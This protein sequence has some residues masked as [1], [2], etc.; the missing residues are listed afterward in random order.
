MTCSSDAFATMHTASVSG[1]DEV[2]EHL[3]VV[4]AHPGLL[5]RTERDECRRLTGEA[6]RARAAKNSSSFGLAPGH[7]PSMY[8]TPR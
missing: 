5:R 7:P 4:G 2:A 8:A 3:V 1:L 6:R